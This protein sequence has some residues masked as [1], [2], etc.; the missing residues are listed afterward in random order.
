[1][2]V[3][4]KKNIKYSLLLICITMLSLNSCLSYN[5]KVIFDNSIP[6]EKSA[7]ILPG[8]VG[9]ITAYNEIEV[10]WGGYKFVQ[11]PAGTT[12]LEWEIQANIG[13]TIYRADNILF[14][15]NFLQGK[16]Y[17]LIFG[18][19]PEQKEP[20]TGALGIKLYIYNMG[21]TIKFSDSEME[22]HFDGFAPFLNLSSGKRRTVLE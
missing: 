20:G 11:I 4:L 14:R 10:N 2:I 8:N 18:R 7:W 13:N 15:Y 1:M 6:S 3:T 19:D 22:K 12:L 16:Q 5:A 21:E 17:Y 9:T